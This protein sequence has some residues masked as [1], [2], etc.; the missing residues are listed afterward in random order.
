MAGLGVIA[1]VLTRRRRLMVLGAIWYSV[2]LFSACLNWRLPYLTGITVGEIDDATIREYADNPR[3]LPAIDG[4]P[5]VPDVQHLLI[6][7]SILAA[8]ALLWAAVAQMR[9]SRRAARTAS[10]RLPTSSLR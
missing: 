5:I 1:A 6:H 2:V 3:V 4:H 9:P 8:C 7:A 10:W